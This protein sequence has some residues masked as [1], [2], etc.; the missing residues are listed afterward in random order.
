[1]SIELENKVV[2]AAIHA[3]DLF[4]RHEIDI[5]WIF[6]KRNKQVIQTLLENDGE[7]TDFS[8]LLMKIKELDPYTSWTETSLELHSFNFHE[9]DDYE[10]GLDLLKRRRLEENIKQ[11]NE[12]YLNEPT[13]KNL[14]S[15]KD[16]IRELDE[17]EQA[18]DTGS[19][20]S[21]VNSLLHKLEHGS[22]AGILSFPHF[23][24]LLGGGLRGGMLVTIGARPSV[25]KTAYAI[26]M[27]VEML[28]K[29]P[30]IAI[31]FFTLEMSKEQMLDRFIS[32]IGNINSYN[33][34]KPDVRLDENQ[35]Q[36]IAID[37]KKLN[38]TGLRVYDS[39]HT[40]RQIEKQIRRR[41]HE[42]EGKP[43]IAIIDYI[44]LIETD[45]RRM[46]RHLQV[47]EIT[48][49]LKKVTNELNVPIIELSQLN[50]GV[51]SRQDKTPN[52][53]DLRE[54]GS[55]EQDSNV[56]GFLHRNED[57]E[58]IVHLTIAKNREG[59]TNTIDYRFHGSTM[60]FEEV[61]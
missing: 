16:R 9:L 32:R 25:G 45:N 60:F 33:L 30:D 19:L 47:G 26:N 46:D 8:D 22:E 39:M 15:L 59:Y 13:K 12:R 1:M 52:L 18:R 41:V 36:R 34:R 53:S 29:Q 42:N 5:D 31:D 14:L 28:E 11:A 2:G 44:G 48:R 23:D 40:I 55:I 6:D 37:A 7:F 43:Y 3:P 20:D 21:A 35:K 49:T 54:S 50:R 4:K 38:E 24:N 51:E 27:A 10:R 56:V 57:D 61:D 17:S 58:T